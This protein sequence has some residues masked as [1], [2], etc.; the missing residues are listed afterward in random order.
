M[1]P[2]SFDHRPENEWGRSKWARG[3]LLNFEDQSNTGHPY[4]RHGYGYGPVQSLTDTITVDHHGHR[5]GRRRR[6]LRLEKS[7]NSLR[8]ERRTDA[9]G[10]T[11]TATDPEGDTIEWTLAGYDADDFSIS[12]VGVLTFEAS[13]D[14]EAPTDTGR[15]N[16]YE[17]TVEASR[18]RG[19]HR[20]PG[21]DGHGHQ[22]GG[23]WGRSPVDATARG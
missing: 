8:G 5:R 15:N 18:Q 9:V 16:V 12:T 4:E 13:P 23:G 14:F 17:V 2:T 6:R 10:T 11:Y 7:R 20:F 22:R 1:T 19:Q 3:R 21:R